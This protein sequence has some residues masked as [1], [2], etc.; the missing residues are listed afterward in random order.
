MQNASPGK[1]RE[2]NWL[3]A[4]ASGTRVT[5]LLYAPRPQALDGRWSPPP[6]KRIQ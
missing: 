1:D 5:M 3:S 6:V 4:P 2:S